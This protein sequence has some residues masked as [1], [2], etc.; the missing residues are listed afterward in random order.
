M[1]EMQILREKLVKELNTITDK[2]GE[3]TPACLESIQKLTSSIKNIDTIIAMEEEYGDNYSQ[4]SYNMGGNSYRR[5]GRY[6]G[7]Y[8]YSRH[9]QLESELERMRRDGVSERVRDAADV[10]LSQLQ[11]EEGR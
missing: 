6:S 11:Y 10:I 8:R 1:N 5:G 9:T 4:R 2:G 7:S 3:M